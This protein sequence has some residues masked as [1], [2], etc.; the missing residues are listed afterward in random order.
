LTFPNFDPVL[1]HIGPLAIRWY[2]LAYIAGIL[3]GWRYGV[4]LVKNL[5]LW[6]GTQ[7]PADERLIDDLVLWLTVAILVGG[8]LGS[9]LFYN[10]SLIWT[11]PLQIFEPWLGGMSFHGALIAVIIALV[12]FSRAHKVDL[13]R[14]ADITAPCV[15]FGLFFGRVAN[16]VNGELWGRPTHVPWAIVFCNTRLRDPVTGICPAGMLPR[17]PSELYEAGLE[18][19]TLFLILRFATHGAKLLHRRGALTGLFLTFYGLFRI[20]LENVR[21][22]DVGMPNFPFGLTMGMILSIPMVL[23]GLTFLY[24]SC[25][26]SALAAQ[27]TP[28]AEGDLDAGEVDT[29]LKDVPEVSADT[30]PEPMVE[31][32]NAQSPPSGGAPSG[33]S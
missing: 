10:T 12:W 32:L 19:I 1:V 5:K 4:A 30:F 15:P 20:S 16:F 23:A 13:V 29:T 8:R 28:P 22:P 2:A 14:L 25:R 27:W 17:H 3:L 18:G 21:E 11:D 26:P 7:P 6:R 33:S 31:P 24:S 9:V